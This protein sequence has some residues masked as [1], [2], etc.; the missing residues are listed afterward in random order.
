MA[1]SKIKNIGLIITM[2]NNNLTN[3]Q[4]TYKDRDNKLRRLTELQFVSGSN[5]LDKEE[6]EELEELH[7]FF[8]DFNR[9]QMKKRL[10]DKRRKGYY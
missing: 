1:Q 8:R 9:D 4:N 6:L 3:L 7:Q 10:R 5:L 2:R